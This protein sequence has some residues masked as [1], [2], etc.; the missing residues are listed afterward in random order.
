MRRVLAV[1]VGFMLSVSLVAAVKAAPGE[2]PGNPQLQQEKGGKKAMKAM[3]DREQKVQETK[4][5]ASAMKQQAQ[6]RK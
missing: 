1:A 5:K 2:S 4:K 6:S 3:R